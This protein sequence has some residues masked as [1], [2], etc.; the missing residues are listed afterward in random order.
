MYATPSEIKQNGKAGNGCAMDTAGK[1]ND[2]TNK[3]VGRV[4]LSGYRLYT[5]WWVNFRGA[6]FCEKSEKA[7]KI[8]IVVLNF[9]TANPVNGCGA[10]PM[11]NR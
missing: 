11:I 7:L 3:P 6:N 4:L 5:I 2:K 8:N 1:N 9:M 10:V